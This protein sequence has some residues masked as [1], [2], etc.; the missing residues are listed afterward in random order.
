MFDGTDAATARADTPA[1]SDYQ[2]LGFTRR[3]RI[4]LGGE[5]L[6]ATSSKAIGESEAS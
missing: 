3:P 2:C 5:F 4:R 1:S 6:G